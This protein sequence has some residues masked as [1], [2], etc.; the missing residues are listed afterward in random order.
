MGAGDLRDRI[1]V[2]RASKVSNGRGG[3]TSAVATVADRLPAKI[4]VR[5]GG[6]EI[7]AK[8]LTGVTPHDITVRYDS[9][10][11]AISASDTLTDQHGTVYAIKWVGS[12]DEGRKRWLMIMADT[13]TVANR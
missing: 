6:E 4:V 8:R 13:G 7:Q 9:V 3:T 11:A 5:K 2:T 10:S 12:L 1:T